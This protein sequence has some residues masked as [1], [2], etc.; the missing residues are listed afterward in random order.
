[1][2]IK[3]SSLLEKHIDKL[4]PTITPSS[5]RLGKGHQKLMRKV[6]QMIL[7]NSNLEGP[8]I[9]KS[10]SGK[11]RKEAIKKKYMIGIRRNSYG[12]I[13]TSI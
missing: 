4:R 11:T 3:C 5:E 12:A 10:P 1:M 6:P 9:Q 13:D 2:R 7:P 8:I